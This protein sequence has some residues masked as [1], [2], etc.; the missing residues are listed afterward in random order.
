MHEPAKEDLALVDAALR[1][2]NAYARIVTR[3]EGVLERYV[4]RLLGQNAQFVDDVLQETFIKAYVNLNG[5][6]R[7]R[8]FAPWLYR[9]A[10]NEA[11]TF[12][13]RR[14]TQP[15][16][17]AGEE[18]RIILERTADGADIHATYGF[19]ELEKRIQAALAGLEQRYR[20]VLVLR[21]LE[22]RSYDDIA[23]IL[24]LPPGTVATRLKRGLQRLK[25]ALNSP[26]AGIGA[27]LRHE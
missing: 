24:A 26:E 15:Q 25:S 17:I 4:R 6:D 13:R 23:D 21:Y 11:V 7:S 9:I 16:V 20:D 12:L 3:Y 19:I 14:R 1:D 27:Y 22:E 10:H 8:P 18:G 5:Y 2:R